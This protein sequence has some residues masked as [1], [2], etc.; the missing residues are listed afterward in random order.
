MKI[1]NPAPYS[2]TDTDETEAINVLVSLLDTHLIKHNI[3]SRD[4][5]PNYDGT[6]EIVNEKQIPIGKIDIQVRKIPK[7]QNKYSCSSK[8]VGYSVKSTLPFILICV[9]IDNQKAF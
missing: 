3:Q 8:L 1:H 4:K 9:D 2:N 5:F 6:L 7:S